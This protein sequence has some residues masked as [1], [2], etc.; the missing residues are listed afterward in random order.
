MLAGR[1]T[2]RATREFLKAQGFKVVEF[3][4]ARSIEDTKAQIRRMGDI[5]GHPDR[6]TALIDRI[7]AAVVRRVRLS[8]ASHCGCSRCRAAAGLPAAKR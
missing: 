4:P 6:A 8:R 2:K 1:F 3:D 7:D 5:M